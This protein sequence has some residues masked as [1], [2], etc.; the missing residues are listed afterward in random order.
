MKSTLPD[1]LLSSP[2]PSATSLEYS[3]TS[4]EVRLGR[5]SGKMKSPIKSSQSSE[6]NLQ[7][8]IVPEFPFIERPPKV[9][10]CVPTEMPEFLYLPY[11]KVRII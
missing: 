4:E 11:R 3:P 2:G 7:S 10:E 1:E 5:R 9:I 6:E 8:F